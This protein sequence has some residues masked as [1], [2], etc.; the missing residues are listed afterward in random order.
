[1]MEL[2]DLRRQLLSG[3]LTQ[4]QSRDVKRH[5]TVRLDWGNE[6]L[7]LDLVPRKEFEMVDEDQISVSDLYK[8]HLSSRHSVQQSSTQGEN[9]RQRHG[10]PCRVPVPHHLLVNLKSF[11]YNSI[12][13]DTDIFFSLFDLREGKTISEKFMVRLNKNGG[14]KNPEKV[15]RLCALF[16]DLSNKD[17]KRDLYIVSQVIRTGRMLLNDSK[18]GPAHVQYRRPYGCAVLAMSDVLQIISELKEEKDFVLKVY[19]CNNENEWYQIH[20]NIIRKSSTKYT[21][22]S[23]NYGRDRLSES[24]CSSAVDGVCVMGIDLLVE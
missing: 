10:E 24:V 15:D 21:A 3:H 9:S 13:E 22:P 19:T 14:P 12:G 1:M 4:D 6:H 23:T 17:M 20:E 2:I 16:T 8:M 5:I 18:K 7:G 11:T